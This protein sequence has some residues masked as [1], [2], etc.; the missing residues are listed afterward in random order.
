MY[1]LVNTSL[2]N[3]LI[4]GTHGFA[5]VAMTKGVQDVLRGRLE[6]L[7]AYTHRTSVHDASYYQQ[8]PV[9]WFHVMLPQG[10][11]VI[12]RVAPSDFDYTGR[13]NRLARIRVF[14]ANEM[15]EVGGA[16]I[17]A[18]E[19]QWFA[20][21]WV[22]EPRYLD[23]DKNTCAHLRMLNPKIASNAPAWDA[24]FGS[25]GSRYAQQVA[26]Q[27]EKNLIAG[28]K[29]IYF[30][31]STAWDVSG[32][33][34]LGLFIDVINL[35]PVELRARVT[36]STYPVSLPVGTGCNLRGIYD[37]D[38]FFDNSSATQ[39]WVDCENAK[40]VHEE[41]LP[42][43]GAVRESET[44]PESREQ[45]SG[46][47][48]SDR[49][50]GGLSAPRI[51]VRRGPS[52]G[53]D[54][55]AYRN[56]IAPKK[57]GPDMFVVGLV[58]A[59]VLLLAVA[60][61]IA[62]WVVTDGGKS[63]I[64]SADNTVEDARKDDNSVK[65]LSPQP[66]QTVDS[67]EAKDF[68]REESLKAMDD[69]RELKSLI[70]NKR[71]K[72]DRICELLQAVEK[73][74][75]AGRP[76]DYAET[77]K[78]ARVF[79]DV[80]KK[81]Q[82]LHKEVEQCN[83]FDEK[84][85][86][87]ALKEKAESMREYE[88]KYGFKINEDVNKINE[89][90]GKKEEMTAKE[91]RE[92]EVK[93]YLSAKAVRSRTVLEKEKEKF[94][95]DKCHVYYYDAKGRMIVERANWVEKKVS[96]MQASNWM[97]MYGKDIE[98]KGSEINK[99]AQKVALWYDGANEV[100]YFQQIRRVFSWTIT[101]TNDV[102]FLDCEMFGDGDIRA[103]YEK[104]GEKVVYQIRCEQ[105]AY[106]EK[107]ASSELVLEEINRRIV[108]SAVRKAEKVVEQKKNYLEDFDKNQKSLE[109]IKN[110]LN[111]A[112]EEYDNNEA[113]IADNKKRMDGIGFGANGKKPGKAEQKKIRDTNNDLR[114]KNQAIL[115]RLKKIKGVS[116][117]KREDIDSAV[118]D[119]V[120]RLNKKR[121]QEELKVAEGEL[122]DIRTGK[123]KVGTLDP[124]MKIS[125]CLVGTEV[126][127]ADGRAAE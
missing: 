122:T 39:A 86:L 111:A 60:G 46:D 22:G 84:S 2:P 47:G 118:S 42:T 69:Y 112:A 43:S 109:D 99:D 124:G 53:G 36:F 31:T 108:D 19:R 50:R 17:L 120:K 102:I 127:D 77:V 44:R 8:N 90:I 100:L 81:Y 92:N 18:K 125:V 9:N 57:Q 116:V 63:R 93:A 41:L 79:L 91:K 87:E 126:L 115:D 66:V 75:E 97:L 25:R 83:Q 119:I 89:K 20:Q 37:R 7:C 13:T 103:L 82:D 14:G 33:K 61:G 88:E 38:K 15:P 68:G 30:K 11:H 95:N 65:P 123:K 49:F 72:H 3:G 29:A 113:A 28:G 58:V 54:P 4:A 16:E 78:C 52:S 35:L 121:L 45:L 70:K 10:E 104:T 51:G 62:W 107:S 94:T 73:M 101:K 34:L 23:E 26:W 48:A 85:K 106:D 5:T 76:T 64:T 74:E 27:I 24:V 80:F 114:R 1:E 98:K 110:Q 96:G 67:L 71:W 59:C 117:R 12:G 105:C 56:L 21:P 40:I 55:Y 32:E 6:A